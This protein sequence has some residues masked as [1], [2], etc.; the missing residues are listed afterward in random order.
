[1][2][3]GRTAFVIDGFNL[4]HSLVEASRSLKMPAET[5]TKWLNLWG[6]C[7]SYL[8]LLGRDATLV[9][10]TTSLRSSITLSTPSPASRLVIPL[11]LMF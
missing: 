2:G 7:E 3:G 8:P 4:Y 10:F 6:L 11:T 5:G 9:G 1:M